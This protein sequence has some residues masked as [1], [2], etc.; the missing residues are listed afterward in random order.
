MNLLGLNDFIG[1][2]RPTVRFRVAE[3]DFRGEIRRTQSP[4]M[5]I[6][7]FHNQCVEMMIVFVVLD[8]T[9]L[10]RQG[11]LEFRLSIFRWVEENN[12]QFRSK[13]ADENDRRRQAQ[14]DG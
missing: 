5:V 8:Q 2:H 4:L 13:E 6:H 11:G 14:T 3:S 1:I 12:V 7:R 9:T 10:F